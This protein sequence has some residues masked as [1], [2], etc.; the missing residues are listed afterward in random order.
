MYPAAHS[1]HCIFCR[2]IG[3]CNNF[4]MAY[5]SHTVSNRPYQTAVLFI[6]VFYR[7]HI[8][9]FIRQCFHKIIH[10]VVHNG[11]HMRKIRIAV[12]PF[13]IHI[14]PFLRSMRFRIAHP[15]ITV[16]ETRNIAH[17]KGSRTLSK[18]H[19]VFLVKI[20]TLNHFFYIRISIFIE[21]PVTINDFQRLRVVHRIS[22]MY[23]NHRQYGIYTVIRQDSQAV[24]L[25]TVC[26]I[27]SSKILY[28]RQERNICAPQVILIF[29]TKQVKIVNICTVAS[30][31]LPFIGKLPC[32][33]LIGIRV[34]DCNGILISLIIDRVCIDL[35]FFR[36]CTSLKGNR[37]KR[38]SFRSRRSLT[39]NCAVCSTHT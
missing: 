11:L 39:Q 33:C 4:C 3:S 30:V 37:H 7:S 27:F 14:Q 19:A 22:R 18:L 20:S 34:I 15:F 8:Y 29:N 12:I 23:H 26:K 2:F 35:Y 31:S 38:I 36:I 6:P 21:T 32:S 17:A 28:C 25:H 10:I 1:R 16:M 9:I 5:G 24:L 13:V